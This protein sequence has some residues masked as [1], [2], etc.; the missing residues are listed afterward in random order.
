M[1]PKQNNM[2]KVIDLATYKAGYRDSIQKAIE[3]LEQME[4]DLFNTS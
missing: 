2:S 3:D 1:S 4:E